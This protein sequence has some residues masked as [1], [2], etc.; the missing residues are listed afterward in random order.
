MVRGPIWS[1]PRRDMSFGSLPF[2]LIT[3]VAVAPGAHLTAT[4]AVT[5]NE[6]R[7][8]VDLPGAQHSFDLFHS[9]RFTAVV[10]GIAA[11]ATWSRAEAS[12]RHGADRRG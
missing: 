3:L 5:P 1:Y 11:F 4:A 6:P 7:F 10:D 9:L 12:P 8:F 2:A